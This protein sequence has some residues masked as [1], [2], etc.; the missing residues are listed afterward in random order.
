MFGALSCGLEFYQRAIDQLIGRFGR[1]RG[2]GPVTDRGGGGLLV[3]H[4]VQLA[5][6][7]GSFIEAGRYHQHRHRVR[8]GLPHR[9]HYIAQPR[10]RD[11]VS[12]TRTPRRAR[13]A[14]GHETCALLVTGEDMGEACLLNAAIH[15]LVM[16]AG[17]A[18]DMAH[19][20]IFQHMGDLST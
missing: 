2:M 7:G 1:M 17:D 19:A 8:I 16:H 11:H 13:V 3:P 4:L 15:L 18:E 10:P 14:I 9:R 12:H 6:F 20:S 5:L